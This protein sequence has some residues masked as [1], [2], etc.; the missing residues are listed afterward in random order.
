VLAEKYGQS[1]SDVEEWP[2]YWF[3]RAVLSLEV[4][5]EMDRRFQQKLDRERR[6]R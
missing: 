6:R 4:E 5:A 3:N 1:P 2:E